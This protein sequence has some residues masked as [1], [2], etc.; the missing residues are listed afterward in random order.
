MSAAGAAIHKFWWLL[1]KVLVVFAFSV[2]ISGVIMELLGG[3]VALTL[4][5]GSKQSKLLDKDNILP[6]QPG[7]I[8]ATQMRILR[9]PARLAASQ[10]SKGLHEWITIC[11]KPHRHVDL[12][13]T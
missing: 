12:Q 2:V 13:P 10:M 6:D 11:Q 3:M 5:A 4:S 9:L 7:L 1:P 8:H